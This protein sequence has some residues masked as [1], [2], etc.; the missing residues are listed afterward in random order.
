MLKAIS[1][2]RFEDDPST[3]AN[4]YELTHE[5]M[6]SIYEYV[7]G[8]LFNSESFDYSS[9]DITKMLD[10]MSLETSEIKG[11]IIRLLFNLYEN[12]YVFTCHS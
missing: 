4:A 6:K 3:I 1:S 12:S 5:Q 7:T 10:K 11:E 2:S 9:L 8:Q